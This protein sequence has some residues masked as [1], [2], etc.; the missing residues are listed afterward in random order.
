MQYSVLIIASC[1]WFYNAMEGA[2]KINE[3]KQQVY[4]CKCPGGLFERVLFSVECNLCADKQTMKQNNAN[5]YRTGNR[6][7]GQRSCPGR[8]SRLLLAVLRGKEG[9]GKEEGGGTAGSRPL[10]YVCGT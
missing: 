9:E 10:F 7:S 6:A 3:E 1:V 8:R 4:V 2:L 5:N